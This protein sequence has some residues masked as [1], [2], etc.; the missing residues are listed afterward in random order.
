[1]NLEGQRVDRPGY[2]RRT[3]L[4]SAI[5]S[6]FGEPV[7]DVIQ[8]LRNGGNSWRTVAGALNISTTTLREWRKVLGL[9][10]DRNK[11]ILDPSSLPERTPTDQKAITLGY[12]S[13]KDAVLEMRT[14]RGMTVQEAAQALGVCAQTITKYTPPDV[15]GIYNRSAYWWE[16]MRK[17]DRKQPRDHPFKLDNNM[18]FAGN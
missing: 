4:W 17:R 6:E 10:I 2:K 3:A 12:E 8:G 18:A 5:E 1:M 11:R 13:A 16:S 15:R 7:A 9:E 14:K